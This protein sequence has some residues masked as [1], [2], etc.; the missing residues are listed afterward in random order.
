ML[1]SYTRWKNLIWRFPEMGVPPCH[2]LLIDFSSINHPAIWVLHG[3]GKQ[4]KPFVPSSLP[5]FNCPCCVELV[6][7]HGH[8][9]TH[10]RKDVGTD[11][12]KANL[13][14]TGKC[15]EHPSWRRPDFFRFQ[16]GFQAAMG[17]CWYAPSVSSWWG[18][19]HVWFSH[20]VGNFIIPTDFHIFQRGGETPP[21][22]ICL[23]FV[24]EFQLAA[25]ERLP[26]VFSLWAGGCS[27]PDG[28]WRVFFYISACPSADLINMYIIITIYVI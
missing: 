1:Q 13:S 18:L 7:H 21:T 11:E 10:G 3:T 5:P 12:R 28:L 23:I 6:P 24:S 8:D 14:K 9:K 19:E 26:K 20:S 2:L 27:Y 17:N 15:L 16:I 25:V 4:R 22:R